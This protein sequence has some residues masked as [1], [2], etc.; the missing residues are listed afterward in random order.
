MNRDEIIINVYNN[1]KIWKFLDKVP[2]NYKDDF[3]QHI[4]LQLLEMPIDKL[5]KAYN[6]GYL[7]FM[8]IKIMGL[9]YN[10]VNSYFYQTHKK[11][12]NLR[13]DNWDEQVIELLL[14]NLY[15]NDDEDEKIL[16]YKKLVEIKLDEIMILLNSLPPDDVMCFKLYYLQNMTY[17]KVANRF[18]ISETNVKKRVYNILNQIRLKINLNIND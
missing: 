13:E 2:V 7:D 10:S 18:K 17:L 8:V 12:N 6:E 11:Y 5:M 3:K 4:L 15:N 14:N 1:S 9:Q 16:E